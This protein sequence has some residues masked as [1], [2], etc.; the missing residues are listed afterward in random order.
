LDIS[1]LIVDRS[2]E[3]ADVIRET[4]VPSAP[5]WSVTY[6][7]TS[8]DAL[9]VADTEAFDAVVVAVTVDD[10]EA[11]KTLASL[12]TLQPDCLRLVLADVHTLEGTQDLVSL[13]HRVLVVPCDAPTLR[14]VIEHTRRLQ[15]TLGRSGVR[16]LG[17]RRRL[18]DSRRPTGDLLSTV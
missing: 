5:S 4:L 12:Q 9:L 6:A 2:P 1:L 8:K 17:L 13:C 11:A 3:F 7:P 14:L 16:A 18:K 10:D 15:D